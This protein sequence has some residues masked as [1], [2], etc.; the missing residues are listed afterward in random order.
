MLITPVIYIPKTDNKLLDSV[1]LY[2]PLTHL[3]TGIRDVATKGHMNNLDLFL[4]CTLL[5]IAAL[6][7]AWKV[8]F[9]G[10]HKVIEKML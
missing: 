5:S 9:L 7:V 4:Y 3:V 10:E 2:N 8:F 1:F 6:I